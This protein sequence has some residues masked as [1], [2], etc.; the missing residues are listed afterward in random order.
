MSACSDVEIHSQ[1]TVVNRSC[2]R[3]VYAFGARVRL[4]FFLFAMKRRE[5]ACTF[6][7][8]TL[9]ALSGP[10]GLTSAHASRSSGGIGGK[11]FSSGS[12]PSHASQSRAETDCLTTSKR[13]VVIRSNL[14]TNLMSNLYHVTQ[15][16][17]F[18]YI[19]SIRASI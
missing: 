2:N 10:I 15:C 7:H 11:L 16:C 6:E 14:I 4:A 1:R 3:Y 8:R 17:M 12:R 5:K 13:R 18:S 19:C 9:Y